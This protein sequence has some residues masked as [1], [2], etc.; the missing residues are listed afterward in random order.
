LI[1]LRNGFSYIANVLV[2]ISAL[3]VFATVNN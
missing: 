1:S 3:I 2:L